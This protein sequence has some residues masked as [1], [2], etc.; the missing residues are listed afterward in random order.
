LN[1]QALSTISTLHF[2]R[3]IANNLQI[4]LYRQANLMR[5]QMI[6]RTKFSNL[7]I[8]VRIR[9]VCTYVDIYVYVDIDLQM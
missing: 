6:S 9:N 1:E 8:T 4:K 5:I 7:L 2:S 3:G